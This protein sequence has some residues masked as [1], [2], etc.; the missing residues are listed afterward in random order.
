M[1][2][3][4]QFTGLWGTSE[5]ASLDA[6][7]D[8]NPGKWHPVGSPSLTGQFKAL[9][10]HEGERGDEIGRIRRPSPKAFRGVELSQINSKFRQCEQARSPVRSNL[11]PSSNALCP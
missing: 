1:E 9:V 2:A 3:V 4:R 6:S 8:G 7:R 10:E 5:H 11:A